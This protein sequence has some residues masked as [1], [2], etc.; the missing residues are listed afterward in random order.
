MTAEGRS[1][2]V[3]AVV[4]A[5]APSGFELDVIAGASG[6]Q[7]RVENPYPQKTGL[8]LAGFDASLQD[9]RLLVFGEGEVRYLA[10]LS[11]ERRREALLRVL[12]RGIPC[13][14]LTKRL[15]PPPGLVEIAD[16]LG[17]PLLRTALPTPRT[18]A[19][20]TALLD[21]QLAPRTHRHGVLLDILGLGVLIVGESGIG[22]SECALELI[23]NG[24]RLVADDVVELR[25][26]GDSVLIG[27]CPPLTR[28]HM[29]LRGIGLIN[30]RDLFGVASTRN[31]KR[32]ELVVQLERWDPTREYERLGLDE[33]YMDILGVPVST[34]C[35]PVSAGRNIAILVE[36]AAR[37]HLLRTRGEHAARRFAARL[38]EQLRTSA[39]DE[40]SEDGEDGE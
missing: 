3:D 39:D 23:V 16:E 25:R 40:G 26:R 38:D 34:V 8:A 36:V 13:I 19:K 6:L 35:M 31:S 20:L 5:A 27:S 30:V 11:P 15:D 18:L 24:H 37:N 12:A 1:V 14:V 10:D 17:V 9:G 2:T 7:R 21:D 22:K 29:E 32:V 4:R 33:V 28:H